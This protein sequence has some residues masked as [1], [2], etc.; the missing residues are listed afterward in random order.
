MLKTSEQN[1]SA[2]TKLRMSTS[3]ISKVVAERIEKK[4]AIV[5]IAMYFFTAFLSRSRCTNGRAATS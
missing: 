2:L 1:Q 5:V 4:V 3:G